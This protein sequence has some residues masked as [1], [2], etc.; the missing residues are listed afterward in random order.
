MYL[1]RT[2][3]HTCHLFFREE[4]LSPVRA[5]VTPPPDTFNRNGSSAATYPDDPATAG[6][7]AG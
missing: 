2:G 5:E 6:P 1:E 7:D 3:V 4:R